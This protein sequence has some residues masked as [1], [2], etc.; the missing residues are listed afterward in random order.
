MTEINTLE[1]FE[2]A[3]QRHDLTHSYSDDGSV[4]RSG[5]ADLARIQAAAKKF[6]ADEVKRIW[7]AAVDKKLVERARQQFYWRD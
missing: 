4:W 3:V 7:N 6:P 5:S 1:E 2:I